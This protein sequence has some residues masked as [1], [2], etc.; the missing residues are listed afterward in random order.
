[1]SSIS[2]SLKAN[3]SP[4][5]HPESLSNAHIPP[6]PT[7]AATF[8]QISVIMGSSAPCTSALPVVKP[9]QVMQH[10][11]VW[12]PNVV[13]VLDGDIL[14]MSVTFG[15]VEDATPWGMWSITAQSICLPNQMLEA[16]MGEPTLTMMTSTPLWM[17]TREIGCVEPGAQ[18]YKGG[19]VTIS[20]LS[21]V[22][23]LVS[24]VQYPYFR[25]AP[26]C[27]ETNLYL[28]IFL[29]YSSPFIVSL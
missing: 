24:V 20:F 10:I 9:C 29:L 26:L 4:L 18:V 22:F 2:R 6:P 23:F 14:I 1:M 11:I 7:P 21:H 8:A 28:L 5:Q 17:T 15:S 12:Q 3:G 19:N 25:F 27:E 16:L 13:S